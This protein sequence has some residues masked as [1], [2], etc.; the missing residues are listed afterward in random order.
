[1]ATQNFTSAQVLPGFWGFIDYNSQGGA[2]G[3]R[4]CLLWG[5]IKSTAQRTPN[6]PFLPAS[7]Q[8]ADDGAG[9]GSD[10][11]RAYAAAVSQPESQGAEV[12][13]MP[14]TAPSG[15]V[16]SVY[17]LK[18]VIPNTNP[19]KAGTLQLWVDS[20]AVPPVGFTTA[21]TAATIAASLK[22]ALETMLDLPFGTISI[23]TDELTIPYV[24]K[25]TV[26]EDLP[27]R[28][29]IS[30]SGTGVFLSPGSAV[31][32]TSAVGAGSV[33][34]TVGAT[35]VSTT[36]SGG[37]ASTAVAT[38][39]AASW[40]ADTYPLTAAVSSSTV[41]FYF[42]ND[43]DVR[44][45]TASVITS[46]GTTVNLGSGVTDGTGSASSFSYNGTVGTTGPTLT[47]ALSNLD[48]LD[49]FRS[50]AAPWLD[51]TTLGTMATAIEN[52]DDGSITGQK[53]QLLT[54]C[55]YRSSAV[56]GAIAPAV[57]PNLT[58]TAPHYAI[59]HALDVPV[60]GMM[61]AARVA[62]A[63]AALWLDTPQKNWNGFQIKGSAKVPILTAPV[64]PS[65]S[66][67][68]TDLLTYALAAVVVGPS[69]NYE[70]VK[71]RTTSLATDRRLWAWSAEAQAAY[72]K[73]DLVQFL[74]DR[75][76]GG[77]IV[78]YSEPKAAM[79]FDA[80]SVKSAIQERMRFWEANGSYDGADALKDYVEVTVD[81]NNPST[82]RAKYPESPVVDL[83]QIVFTGS[84]ASPA[85]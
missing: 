33:K 74:R 60:Q 12:W 39:V 35:S 11:A 44:R 72:H 32:A 77:S 42:A 25:G 66:A 71:G 30:P 59:L 47:S 1:M 73:T 61:V 22:T 7:Q 41:T 76:E 52:A 27:F 65:P 64:R 63:R 46:T 17:K 69:G 5:Y 14:I 79:V 55:D 78:K 3:N 34:V 21:D 56:A 85:Q 62:A 84:F 23:G 8:D 2:A 43:R 16:A 40:N 10:L 57:S 67:Q 83:D 45:M 80:A 6:V 9:R 51:T 68:N 38:A 49:A 26:G 54:V 4:R 70:V 53:D 36:L 75:F 24:H 48:S 20:Q 13:L 29:N 81:L 18:V 15:G 31:F 19:S 58:S 82:F 37:E 28:C 50:W